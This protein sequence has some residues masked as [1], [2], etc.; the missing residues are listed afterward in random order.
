M[1]SFLPLSSCL[2][3][4]NSCFPVQR[5][6][7]GKQGTLTCYNVGDDSWYR[8]VCIENITNLTMGDNKKSR[9]PLAEVNNAEEPCAGKTHT[10][11]LSLTI[12]PP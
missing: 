11:N 10:G 2:Q 4:R 5:E 1:L 7:T 8:I 12:L 3:T 6:L 9:R